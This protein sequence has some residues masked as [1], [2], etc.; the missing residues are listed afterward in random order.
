MCGT[1][2]AW[3]CPSDVDSRGLKTGTVL[4]AA[5]WLS[6]WGQVRCA[7]RA[8]VT[9]EY[10]VPGNARQF[11]PIAQMRAVS[12]VAGIERFTLPIAIDAR[13]RMVGGAFDLSD[14]ATHV[15]YIF[16]DGTGRRHVLTLRK[17]SIRYRLRPGAEPTSDLSSFPDCLRGWRDLAGAS[18]FEGH[19]VVER[20]D[21]SGLRLVTSNGMAGHTARLADWCSAPVAREYE[22]VVGHVVPSERTWPE[23]A[24]RFCDGR[25]V[26]LRR[27]PSQLVD[28]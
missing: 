23:V 8:A 10:C 2:K 28:A 15:E 13:G 21:E 11:D 19:D 6:G 4:I 25:Q 5:L 1:T 12:T 26:P 9:G 16:G 3:P 20:F 18:Q 22:D 27:L 14:K 24:F 7:A 17:G